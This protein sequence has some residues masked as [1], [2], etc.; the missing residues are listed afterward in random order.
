MMAQL[1][2]L[3]EKRR[4]AH[5]AD[6]ARMV[7]M[8]MQHNRDQAGFTRYGSYD[9]FRLFM[10]EEMRVPQSMSEVLVTEERTDRV[11]IITAS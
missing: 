11:A 7:K 8:L 10:L 4:L 2:P 9:V 1:K 3:T 6:L 5:K